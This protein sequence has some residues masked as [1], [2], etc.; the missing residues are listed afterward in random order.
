MAKKIILVIFIGL[1]IFSVIYALSGKKK[2]TTSSD[3]AYHTFLAGEELMKKLY[4]TDAIPEFEK[5]VKIDTNF[6]MA[7]AMLAELYNMH[8]RKDDAQESIQKAVP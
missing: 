1:L 5:A 2:Y 6:A 8:D 3:Q 4:Y 7:Y